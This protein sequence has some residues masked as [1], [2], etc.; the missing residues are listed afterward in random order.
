[1]RKL[2]AVAT[3]LMAAGCN[4]KDHTYPGASLPWA[5]VD[6]QVLGPTSAEACGTYI[7]GID[8]GHLFAD[9]QGGASGGG[10]GDPLSMILGMLPIGG[11]SAEAGRAMYDALEKMPEAT[12]LMAPKVHETVTGLAP[13]GTP[14]FA[15]RC[16]QIEARGVKIGRGPV[17]GAH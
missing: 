9:Q 17:P 8:F 4:F 15:Q 1:M 7:F 12:H 6:Y 2:L 13:F 3:V 10:G 16:A 5:S 11:P 14:F